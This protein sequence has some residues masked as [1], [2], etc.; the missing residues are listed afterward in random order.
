MTDKAPS[1]LRQAARNRLLLEQHRQGASYADLARHH[2]LTASRTRTLI[3]LEAERALREA[4]LAFADTL[5]DQ[6][7]PLHLS[8]RTRAMVAEAVGQ[9]DFTRADVER[10]GKTAVLRIGGFSGVHYREL[11]AWLARPGKISRD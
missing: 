2:G 10:V 4:E 11:K 8:E 1:H 3:L 6:P 7:N 9:E 5:P